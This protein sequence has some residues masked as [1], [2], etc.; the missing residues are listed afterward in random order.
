MHTVERVPSFI[1]RIG[2]VL[3]DQVM[4]SRLV[5][6]DGISEQTDVQLLCQRTRISAEEAAIHFKARTLPRLD[7]STL[8]RWGGT[9]AHALGVSTIPG[10]SESCGF[11]NINVGPTG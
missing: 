9:S 5:E 11:A 3:T 1:Q 2:S 6:C 10:S 4:Q 8:D 7:K